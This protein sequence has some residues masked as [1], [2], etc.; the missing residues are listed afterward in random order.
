MKQAYEN[1]LSREDIRFWIPII[2]FA[3]SI[4]AWG[5]TLKSDIRVIGDRLDNY[6]E[7]TDIYSTRVQN[8]TFSLNNVQ[9]HVC[10]LDVLHNITCIEG[11]K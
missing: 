5:M 3:V 11:G 7:T 6:K 9:T 1:F 8:L 10:R 2:V 4:T